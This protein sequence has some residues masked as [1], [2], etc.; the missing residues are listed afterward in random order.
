MIQ[1]FDSFMMIMFHCVRKRE[2]EYT[3]AGLWEKEYMKIDL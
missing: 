1:P 3:K 2:I